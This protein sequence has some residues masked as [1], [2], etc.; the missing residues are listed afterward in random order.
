MVVRGGA[1]AGAAEPC[2]NASH[3]WLHRLSWCAVP[4]DNKRLPANGK[5]M[6]FP[7]IAHRHALTHRI[8]IDLMPK[9][10]QFVKL[11]AILYVCPRGACVRRYMHVHA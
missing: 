6:H 7:I 3:M 5:G 2:G 1:A 8:C 11:E 4:G 10:V 9:S